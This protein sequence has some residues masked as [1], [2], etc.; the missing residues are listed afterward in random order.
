LFDLDCHQ[1]D[2]MKTAMLGL[3]EGLGTLKEY[4]QTTTNQKHAGVMEEEK[5][6]RCDRGG[7]RGKLSRSK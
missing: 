4:K 6:R 3:L 1:F 2:K 7:V 5:E